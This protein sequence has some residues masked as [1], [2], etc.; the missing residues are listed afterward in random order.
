MNITWL[1]ARCVAVDVGL[2]DIKK[3]RWVRDKLTNTRGQ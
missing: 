1:R 3:Y 2:G